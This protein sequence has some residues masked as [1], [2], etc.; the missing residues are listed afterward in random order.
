MSTGIRSVIIISATAGVLTTAACSSGEEETYPPDQIELIV[1]WA[2]GG[3]TDQ[4]TRQLVLASEE[5]CDTGFVVSN[6][7]GAAGAT[8]HEAIA[9]GDPDGATIGAMTAEATILPHLGG[10][11]VTVED[12]T[13]IMR[14]AAISPAFVV[15]ADSPYETLDDMVAAMK[16]DETLRIGTTG[17]GGIWDIVAGGFEKEVGAEFTERVPYDGGASIIQ[18]I[19]GGQLEV[20]SLAAPEVVDQ[21]EAGELR[22]LGI[23]G[24]ER[25]DVLPDVPTLK[26][27]G[28]DWSTGTWFGAAGPADMAEDQ[29]TYLHD[30]LKRGYDST[31]YQEFLTNAGFNQAYMPPKEFAE[32]IQEENDTFADL[33]PS[34]Y[35]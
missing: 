32:L 24:E 13:P 34:L 14:Y 11:N 29:V 12:F 35:E 25:A 7:T 31:E 17:R 1:P 9:N 27:Q 19:L 18:A 3:G 20:A 4:A 26:E 5:A 22:V 33:V 8:G 28:Y 10:T 2:A 15:Q 21:V 30:C 6:R 16:S 23:A